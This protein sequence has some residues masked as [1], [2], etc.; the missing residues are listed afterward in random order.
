MSS[1]PQLAADLHHLFTVVA[2]ELARTTGFSQR[3]RILDG[4]A[5]VQ[6]LVFGAMNDPT[7]RYDRLVT[8][9]A[10]RGYSITPQAIADRFS[11]TSVT[12]FAQLLDQLLSMLSAA[13]P[14]AIDLLQEWSAVVIQ[15]S[16]TIMLPNE[17]ANE[18]PGRGGSHGAAKAAMT[19]QV[20][21]DILWGN[22]DLFLHPGRCSDRSVAFREPLPQDSLVLRDLGY[23]R[24]ET[25]QHDAAAGRFWVSR[26]YPNITIRTLDGRIGTLDD[27][28]PTVVGESCDLPVILGQSPR[29]H[30]RLVA[31]RVPDKLATQRRERIAVQERREGRTISAWQKHTCDWLLAVT[32]APQERLSV[33]GVHTLMR[34]R[35]QI[36]LL[37][38]LWK[39]EGGLGTSRGRNPDRI[40]TEIYVK[41]IALIVQHWMI[42]TQG[43]SAADR[44]LVRMVRV[45]QDHGMWLWLSILTLGR[46]RKR[47]TTILNQLLKVPRHHK[48]TKDPSTF[49][50][51]MNPD[52]S[53]HWH[54]SLLEE[55]LT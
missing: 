52:L 22:V 24:L 13:D 12:L 30:A 55:P 32:N 14:V 42:L 20:R 36:E 37:F 51:L 29:V 41:L 33:G 21:F 5:F 40:M 31:V 17:L 46:L 2:P 25:M 4:A 43:W 50:L 7:L 35:W 34:A 9:A 11:A 1:I 48:R 38:K 54:E 15:D 45:I 3:T 16:T 27:I 39:S 8:L 53:M 18:W 23:W 47:L 44:S 26:V 6:L 49:Q 10:E 28:L 19:C